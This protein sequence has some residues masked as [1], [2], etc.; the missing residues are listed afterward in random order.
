MDELICP[1]CGTP[2]PPDVEVCQVCQRRFP[3]ENSQEEKEP[4]FPADQ[5]EGQ[6]S[7]SRWELDNAFLRA[8]EGIES[9]TNVSEKGVEEAAAEGSEER[10]ADSGEEKQD[11]ASEEFESGDALPDW[12][13][14]LAEMEFGEQGIG[15]TEESGEEDAV[16][17]IRSHQA[18]GEFSDLLST[19]GED[20]LDEQK[21]ADETEEAVEDKSELEPA[22]LPD[23]LAAIK[24][25]EYTPP[26]IQLET[27]PDEHLESGGPLAGIW[28]ALQPEAD[29]AGE[30]EPRGSSVVLSVSDN[31]RVHADLLQGMLQESEKP[32]PLPES[33]GDSSHTPIRWVI[34][35]ILILSIIWSLI[36]NSNS[37]S[38]RSLAAPPEVISVFNVINRLSAQDRVLVAFE[39][40]PGISPELDA[41]AAP[42][43]DHLLL[44]DAYLTLVSTSPTGP[45]LAERFL[46]ST[47]SD[48]SISKN[49]DYVNLGFIPA[50]TA[51]LISFS[52]SPQRTLP[53]TIES[54][55][56]W[57]SLDRD[58]VLPLQGIYGVADYAMVVVIVDQPDVARA[59]IEQVLPYLQEKL[60]A[61]PLV[62]ITSAQSEPL[63][64][65]YYEAIPKQVQGMVTSLAGG[66]SYANLIGR[67]SIAM[68]YWRAFD[69]GLI[70]A[71]LLILVGGVII[72]SFN[73]Y[74]QHKKESG[75]TSE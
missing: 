3:Q 24:P 29:L 74:V 69:A 52:Q 67:D 38:P 21:E 10:I 47:Q 53:F 46:A 35:I 48:H 58:A 59:W 65:P 20:V 30:G 64:R 75:E 61:I 71:A 62:M 13:T 5:E 14:S 8:L 36:D 22:E 50:G 12:L 32:S 19:S 63:I 70:V 39:F 45:L 54:E 60:P 1:H 6:D 18:E 15:T 28:G 4:D 27:L 26:A 40:E 66:T 37:Q 16:S 42:I 72:V 41:A 56:A 68:G 55:L 11:S 51:G 31:H 9:I 2:N 17:G 43:I 33:K 49:T 73:F 25:I 44:R 57:S 7:E 34:A 23:W